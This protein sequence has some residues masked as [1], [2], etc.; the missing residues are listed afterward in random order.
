LIWNNVKLKYKLMSENLDNFFYDPEDRDVE[1][2]TEEEK[3]IVKYHSMNNTY[4]L[5]MS[6]YDFTVFPD[7]LFWLLTDYDKASVFD[8][9][10]E[11]FQDED[12][13]EYEKCAV[14]KQLKE[15]R[16]RY[17]KRASKKGKFTYKLGVQNEGL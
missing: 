12:R 2:M 4:K 7:T 13:E 14:L 17:K 15:R 10:I 11:Y 5:I 6:E 1:L 16:L 8:V 9:L 3:E